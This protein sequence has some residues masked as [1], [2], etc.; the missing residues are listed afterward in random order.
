MRWTH[1]ESCKI[2]GYQNIQPSGLPVR[3]CLCSCSRH[4]KPARWAGTVARGRFPQVGA[5]S[6]VQRWQS[7][8]HARRSGFKSP[9]CPGRPVPGRVS[10]RRAPAHV[11]GE[12]A[13]FRNCSTGNRA[14][15]RSPLQ[16]GPQPTV[17][18][19]VPVLQTPRKAWARP[20]FR[21][22]SATCYRPWDLGQVPEYS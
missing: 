21:P 8:P 11:Q 16:E 18:R 4:P 9:C 10:S 22:S 20:G 19:R 1:C 5:L 15:G 3:T 6:T 14:R 7:W 12:A 17:C 2:P 13:R